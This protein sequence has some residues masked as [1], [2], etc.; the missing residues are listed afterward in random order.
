[1]SAI[2][3]DGLDGN[4]KLTWFFGLLVFGLV[5][6]GSGKISDDVISVHIRMIGADRRVVRRTESETPDKQE[7]RTRLHLHGFEFRNGPYQSSRQE[8]E[9]FAS[10]N[11]TTESTTIETYYLEYT[12]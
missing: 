8:T 4:M 5:C 11:G 12:V 1:M 2:V 10:S 3:I 7:V 6:V 9:T